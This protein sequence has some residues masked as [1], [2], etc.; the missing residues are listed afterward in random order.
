MHA[1]RDAWIEAAQPA[2]AIELYLVE[3]AVAASIALDRGRAHAAEAA[4]AATEKEHAQEVQAA[5]PPPFQLEQA[6]RELMRDP[7]AALAR[8]RQSAAGSAWLR[9]RWQQLKTAL[10]RRDMWEPEDVQMALR[11]LGR[12]PGLALRQDTFAAQVL[13]WALMV[14]WDEEEQDE[15]CDEEEPDEACDE[16]EQD[17]ACDEDSPW[18]GPLAQILYV[19]PFL[20]QALLMR[21]VEDLEDEAPETIAEARQHLEALVEDQWASLGAVSPTSAP[22]CP[23]PAAARPIDPLADPAAALR[24][25]YMTHHERTLMQSLRMLDSLQR[26]RARNDEPGLPE[27]LFETPAPAE[28]PAP[29]EANSDTT[30]CEETSSSTVPV[31]PSILR[32][33]RGNPSTPARRSSP[34]SLP[35]STGPRRP[36]RRSERYNCDQNETACRAVGLGVRAGC[37]ADDPSEEDQSCR[38]RRVRD[39]APLPHPPRTLSAAQR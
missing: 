29:N 38:V 5:A 30:A 19:D 1:R 4:I 32:W 3:S 8:F 7:A 21:L 14:G 35:W 39:D 25:R 17:E 9:D 20:N 27:N 33:C 31:V 12:D 37:C 24:L 23:V 22:S 26:R 16:E 34:L 2:N 18:R 13:A 36:S 6:S 28:P 15:E 10:E 11:L